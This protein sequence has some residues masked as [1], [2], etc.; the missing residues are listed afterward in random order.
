MTVLV[1][2]DDR[3][4]RSTITDVLEHA[5][6]AV[7]VGQDA[8]EGLRLARER[9]PDV[10][11]LDLALPKRSGLDMLDDLKGSQETRSIP[12]ILITAYAF[13]L[14]SSDVRLAASVIQKPFNVT[15]LLMQVNQAV[16]RQRG[17]ERLAEPGA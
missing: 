13:L 12:V 9:R 14:R 7:V 3:I 6:Y 2:D 15:D 16:S 11:L 17:H 8:V 5:G 4:I 10:I 1:V